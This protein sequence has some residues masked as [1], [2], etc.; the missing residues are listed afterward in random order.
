MS[1]TKL[2]EGSESRNMITEL[3]IHP[4]NLTLKTYGDL[5]PS[6]F[7]VPGEKYPQEGDGEFSFALH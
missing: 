6:I 4:P 7:F 3:R 2:K 1:R 5:Y